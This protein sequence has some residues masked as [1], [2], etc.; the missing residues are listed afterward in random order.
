MKNQEGLK[1]KVTHQSNKV[2]KMIGL[3]WNTLKNVNR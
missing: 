1:K 3:K 2:N